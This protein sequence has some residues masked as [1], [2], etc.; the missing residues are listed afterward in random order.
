MP[1]LR[2]NPTGKTISVAAGTG[3]LDAANEAGIK[4]DAPCGANGTCGKCAVR[5]VEGIPETDDHGLLSSEAVQAGYVHTCKSRVGD[6]DLVVEIPA[7]CEKHGQF[8]D[9]QKDFE[10]INPALF[11]A[12]W[13]LNPMVK[14]EYL[15]VQAAAAEDG[16]SDWDRLIQT[17]KENISDYEIRA[18]VLVLKVLADSLRKENGL[19]TV[20]YTRDRN[21]L[22]IIDLKPGRDDSEY[23]GIAV[24]L[25]T[26]SVSLILT[27]F[28]SHQITGIKT[29][30]N[31]QISCGSDIIS[32]INYAR[33]QERLEELTS[34][35]LE[36][37]NG[38]IQA[39][40][41]EQK[42]TSESVKSCVIS[43]NTTMTHLLLGLNPD[44]IRLDPYTPTFL[45]VP[46]LKAAE[47]GLDLH[48]AAPVYISPAVGSYVGGDITAG[49]LC[50]EIEE[51]CDEIIAFLDIGTNGELALGNS[52]F[53]ISCACSAG[54]AFEG[55][56]MSCGM[57]ATRG[58]IESV[59]INPETG[60][61]KVI[62]IGDTKAEGICG[63]GI[64][65]LIAELSS[66]GWLEPSGKLSRNPC[67]C[68]T[69]SGRQATYTI[70]PEA[71]S[72]SGN[73]LVI[74]ESE[75]ENVIR[76]KAAIYSACMLLIN[77]VGIEPES[78]S[79]FYI[80]GGFGHY[81]NL[82]NCITIG[83]L[84]DLDRTV[85][86]FLGN[87]SLV[88]SQ[89]LL[90]SKDFQIRQQAL[91]WRITY[92]DLGSDPEYMDHYTAALFLPHTDQSLF[93]SLNRNKS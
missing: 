55:G 63:S 35:A 28:P 37:I 12:E 60:K 67:S 39:F 81:L 29:D 52:E 13:Q 47:I 42:I 43:G 78:I 14:R 87:T 86:K 45:R 61:S 16:L 65:S 24:D 74:T 5:I 66:S 51:S 54:P 22:K 20:W 48:H 92:V 8:A 71:D 56:A 53:I 2:F 15:Q 84:P 33:K 68:I 70:V 40:I 1:T 21:I 76:A 62:T 36:S 10:R 88:G 90:T 89:M 77:Q 50:T 72:R 26:T 41:T 64:I 17:I 11:P 32:R 69:I 4:I 46:Q 19:V 93:P 44:H 30:Y 3:L 79:R 85:F 75:I 9:A 38:L 25:G 49:L 58:A 7:R 57:R 27:A 34:L 6:S 83:L 80:A 82:E 59:S 18:T 23:Y 31:R 91:S 73:P